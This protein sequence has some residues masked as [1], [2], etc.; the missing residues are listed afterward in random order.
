[1][2]SVRNQGIEISLRANLLRG[3]KDWSWE[4]GL[5][6]SH[7]RNKVLELVEQGETDNGMG[8]TIQGSGNQVLAEGHAMGAFFGYQ[9]EGIIQDQATI[10]ELNAQAVAAGK[11]TYN[12][13]GLRPGH[14]LLRDVDGNGYIDNKDR[15]IIGS[16]EADLIGGLTSTLAY[17][18]LSLYMH[19]GF[20]IGGKKLFN[21]TLQNLP[22]QL[23]GLVDYNLDNRWSEVIE[24]LNYQPCILVMGLLQIL[25]YPYLMPL[26]F[27]CRNFVYPMIFQNCGE[28]NT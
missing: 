1:M 28:V 27:V 12:G 2:G 6:A 18:R 13:S 11:N 20:Q 10:N 24:M 5:N 19:F 8:I 23:T 26:I 4:L 16:P 7:N 15:M 17:K 14:L 21:K 3:K 22:N 25:L 9:Y